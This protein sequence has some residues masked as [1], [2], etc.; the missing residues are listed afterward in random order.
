VEMV[1]SRRLAMRDPKA[2][3][4]GEGRGLAAVSSHSMRFIALDLENSEEPADDEGEDGEENG[5]GDDGGDDPN[6]LSADADTSMD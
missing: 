5:E 6:D 2:L 3:V 4:T 1:Q